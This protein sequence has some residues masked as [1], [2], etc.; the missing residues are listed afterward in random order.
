MSDR[1]T[2]SL[3]TS[4]TVKAR[5]LG[6]HTHQS[7][8]KFLCLGCGIGARCSADTARVALATNLFLSILLG[9]GYVKLMPSFFCI[10]GYMHLGDSE[11]Y[12][13]YKSRLWQAGRNKDLLLTHP[14]SV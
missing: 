9:L 7:I 1:F 14:C 3:P 2:L 13:F 8:K 4:C 6:L 12:L 5:L 11:L 10:T